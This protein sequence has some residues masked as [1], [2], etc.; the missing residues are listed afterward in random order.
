MREPLR[1]ERCGS[2]GSI[3]FDMCQVCLHD[4]GRGDGGAVPYAPLAELFGLLEAEEASRESSLS[5]RRRGTTK[6]VV[7]A[8]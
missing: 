5:K 4:Y 1:C 2:V 6:E 8:V 3:E 7:A